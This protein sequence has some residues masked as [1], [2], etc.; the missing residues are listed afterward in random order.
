MMP[1]LRA[2]EGLSTDDRELLDQLLRESRSARRIPR[3]TSERAPLSYSQRR[4]W[5]VDQLRPGDPAY[6]LAVTF[7]VSG[8]L[9]A[10]ALGAALTDIATRHDIL[11]TTIQTDGA[12]PYQ[13]IGPARPV[14]CR[15]IDMDAVAAVDRETRALALVEAETRA[16]FDLARG[17]LFRAALVRIAA[18]DHLLVLTMH[19]IVSDGWSMGVLYRELASAYEARRGGAA[20]TFPELP[21]QYGDWAEWQRQELVDERR[22]P[23]VEY[24]RERLRGCSATPLPAD[25]T[26]PATPSTAGAHELLPLDEDALREL[27]ALARGEGAT[28]FMALLALFA[29]LL[30]RQT[31]IGEVIVGIP[32][33]GRDAP[34]VEP[35]IGFFVNMLPLRVRVPPAASFRELVRIVRDTAIAAFERQAL[36]FDVLVDELAV[37][38]GL[39]AHPL[40]QVAFAA[41]D[42]LLQPLQLANLRIEPV[43]LPAAATRFDLEAHVIDANGRLNLG[44]AYRVDLYDRET[45]RRLLERYDLALRRSVANP[46]MPLAEAT[47]LGDAEREDI[48]G[49]WSGTRTPYPGDRS[50]PEL[51]FRQV[52]ARPDAIAAVCNGAHLTYGELGRRANQLA[53]RLLRCGAGSGV[54]V[55]VCLDR[56]L[57]TIVAL[58]AILETGAAYVPLDPAYPAPRLAYMAQDSRVEVAVTSSGLANLVP[59]SVREIVQ[60][61][62]ERDALA[63]EWQAAPAVRRGAL[64]RPCVALPDDLA[65][66]TYTSGS[67]G[68]P[69]GVE[70]THR[71][72]VRLLCGTDYVELGPGETLLHLAPLAFDASTFEI[73]GALLH[74]GRVVLYPDRLPRIEDLAALLRD[75]RVTTLWLTASLYNTVVDQ[76]PEALEGVRQLLIGGEALSVAHVRRGLAALPGTT[77]V[78]GYGPT[79]GTTFTCCHAIGADSV[80]PGTVSIPIG[81]PIANTRVFVL[82]A[83]LEPAGVGVPGELYVGGDGVAR[84]YT[85]APALTAAR[86]VPDP[87]CGVPGARLYRTGDQVR[88]RADGTLEFLGRRDGQVKVRGHRLELGE[89]EAVLTGHPSVRAAAAAVRQIGEAR[90]LVACVVPREGRPFDAAALRAFV[91]E[92]LPEY[93]V[94]AFVLPIP[95]LPLTANGK[96]DREA[97]PAPVVDAAGEEGS[98]APRS[99]VE[100]T[101]A[102]LWAEVLGRSAIGIHD[103]FFDVGGD[104]ILAIQIASRAGRAGLRLAPAHFFQHQ[105]IAE[106]A[107]IVEP[108]APAPAAGQERVGGEAPLTP[109]QR[110][111]FEQRLAVP[112]HFNQAVLL[113]IGRSIAPA[114]AGQA[115]DALVAHHDQLRARFARRGGAWVQA[116]APA[117][118]SVPFAV[119]DVAGLSDAERGKRIERVSAELQA[120]LDLTSGPLVRAAFFHCGA[121]APARLLVIAHHLLVDGV[122]W[123]ILIED[124]QTAIEQLMRGGAV[125][126][127]AKTSSFKRWAEQLAALPADRAWRSFWETSG[128]VAPLPVDRIGDPAQNT[129]GAA[130]TVSLRFSREETSALL[131]DVPAR[132]GARIHEIL[133]A[134]LAAAVGRWSLARRIA[135]DVEG[136]GRE[137]H[138]AAGSALSRT[139]GWF[140]ALYPLVLDLPQSLEAADVLAVVRERLRAVPDGGAG[141]GLLGFAADAGAR[142]GLIPPPSGVGFNYLGQ[143]DQA[144]PQS[145]LLAFAGESAGP[146]V[147]AANRRPFL[148]EI[149]ARVVDGALC[150]DWTYCPAVHDRST[151]ERLAADSA[152]VVRVLIDA[153]RAGGARRRRLLADFPDA[154]LDERQ[155]ASIE[156]RFGAL[157]LEIA[158]IYPVTPLQESML[159]HA[160]AAPG[161]GA[162]VTQIDLAVDRRLDGDALREAWE[163]LQA[164]HAA[165]R[166]AFVEIGGGEFRQVVVDRATLP[167]T[168]YDWTAVEA[169]EREARRVALLADIRRRGFDA[170]RPPL[171]DLSLIRTSDQRS[172]LIWTHHHALVD[173]WSVAALLDEMLHRYEARLQGREPAISDRPRFGGY[174]AWLGRRDQAA[175]QAFW[176]AH[177]AGFT[178]PTTLAVDRASRARIDAPP[179]IADQELMIDAEATRRLSAM[180]SRHRLTLNT[181]VQ[182]AWALLLSRYSGERD[183]LFGTAVAGRPAEL[184]G[185]DRMIGLFLNGVPMRVG[186]D[187]DAPA[188]QWLRGVQAS[189]VAIR[190]HEHTGL[191]DIR[192]WSDVPRGRPLFETTL[193]FE[194]YP[195]AAGTGTVADRVGITGFELVA[196][197]SSALHLR[198]LP[199]E[200]LRLMLS[201]DRHRF[202]EPTAREM[203][204]QIEVLLK[205]MAD[206]PDMPVG[207]LSLATP[208]ARAAR[209]AGRPRARLDW[210]GAAHEQFASQAAAAGERV[211]IDEGGRRQTYAE[212]DRCSGSLAA[213]LA[214]AGA[215]SGSA[216]G[217]CARRGAGLIQALLGVL[218]AGCAF[219]I[220][221]PDYPPPRIVQQIGIAGIRVVLHDGGA[222]PEFLAAWAAETGRRLIPIAEAAHAGLAPLR[223]A[224]ASPDQ[225]AYVAFT[226]GSTG[227]PK[228]VLGLHGALGR[229]GAWLREA[230][231][232]GPADRYSMLT[233]LSHDPLLRDIFAP[234]AAGAAVCIPPV[235]P[236]SDPPLVVRW[237]AAAGVTVSNLTPPMM[238]L[239]LDSAAAV[240][241]LPSLRHAFVV[242]EPLAASLVQRLRRL[243]PAVT[244][245]NLYG[246][247]ETQQSLAYYVVPAL[248]GAADPIVPIGRGMPDVDL[249]V[250]SDRRRVAGIGEIGDVWIRS[251]HLARA[252]LGDAALTR[253]RFV[254]DAF[255]PGSGR[256]YRT[257]DRGRYLP[258][259]EV[260]LIGRIDDQVK[261]RGFRVEI[262]EIDALLARQ[263]GV[264]EAAVA[265]EPAAGDER[266][267]VAYVAGGADIAA[268]RR[269]LRAALPEH[270]VPGRFVP[271]ERLPRT[272]TGKI[273]RRALAGLAGEAPAEPDCVEPR[274]AIEAKLVEIWSGLLARPRLGV[275]DSFFDAGGH[276][277]LAARAVA[278]M[279]DAF[280]IDIRIADLFARPELAALADWI[281]QTIAER[282]DEV[283]RLI[284]EVQALS[285]EELSAMLAEP[286]P[287][288]R[289]ESDP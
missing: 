37:E 87:F 208:A 230:F 62:V 248:D 115:V 146:M 226:S 270:M 66:V 221:D 244:C 237:M 132:T 267:L 152:A 277:I 114:I 263:P 123:R 5:V 254:E 61:D 9:D 137:E 63:R 179:D 279:R 25:R 191:A 75:E 220:L 119:V 224:A 56:S 113:E 11:R 159:V 23:L 47:L 122:S 118:S 274:N 149:A 18:L 199:G 124:L 129:V 32:V 31:D 91:K 19:H 154:A 166:T 211:A 278:R 17:P 233:A 265:A 117:G 190:E 94:P 235:E 27:T 14:S 41:Q 234:L 120:S 193:A 187:P 288:P 7:R 69:K 121:A 168:E 259:G 182:G 110:W 251:A 98:A 253:A 145:G 257:G 65:Y 126:L 55:G 225:P 252:Y 54:R 261:V 162:F 136:H 127:P 229:Y 13:S 144:L 135:I 160:S 74:G 164:A 89:I 260:A 59:S 2:V 58:L 57:D 271:V 35:L 125:H 196:H 104:S 158:D 231:G 173:G 256:A 272:S 71:G 103:N 85:G 99:P 67:T 72:I 48:L 16:P 10:D 43:H 82:D 184:P 238:R 138:L 88:W 22:A 203:L 180:A 108:G 245:V 243:A 176:R 197:T 255:G 148:L 163:A 201:H 284:E 142:G 178:A 26:R 73:W 92:H 128:P 68:T 287:S 133:L 106:Q 29:L 116:I 40:F 39:D 140:T 172:R 79:E 273:D 242:G 217:V 44:V 112:E 264:A 188:A 241:A 185:A 240:R 33:A 4:L 282:D 194:N 247:T 84:G 280:S 209:R 167:W 12:E 21:I 216:I 170:D 215:A 286:P 192:D 213:A 198:A 93:M 266:S 186:V 8:A 141:Y 1:D 212:L 49:A 155:F 64:L 6:N 227:T 157:D 228:A 207:D 34:E 95:C 109:I 169:G 143:F 78:N 52:A 268:L 38:R 151:V 86:F 150:V 30:S 139:V 100:E 51:V 183:V 195:V 236:A 102:S 202:D 239:L 46:D 219:A 275:H 223:S 42:A 258:S 131:R 3:R 249:I 269:A 285:P 181:I 97:L 76:R 70:V 80:G 174:V 24:W 204:R 105:T 15:L 53:N 45:I 96:V 147:A 90:S 206:A 289:G 189:H 36:P 232:I 77:I 218:K 28:R 214:E 205:Q 177:L 262:G 111:F 130:S 161:T 281:Q 250:G 156:E 171:M 60:L 165:L 222:A 50:V 83:A 107:V 210:R 276:S 134:S 20:P 200:R 81:R 175:S 246:A 153:A 283:R 101:L